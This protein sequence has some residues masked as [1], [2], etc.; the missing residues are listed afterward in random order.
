MSLGLH[1]RRA[2]RRRKFWWGVFKW[3]LAFAVIGALGVKAYYTG[4]D[5]AQRDLVAE[6]EKTSKLTGELAALNEK[7]A[8]M[9]AQ[10]DSANL[11]ASDWQKKYEVDVPTGALKELLD[12]ASGKLEGGVGMERLNFLI[13]SAQNERS[14]D[15][16]PSTKRFF[17]GTELYSGAND[18]VSFANSSITITAKGV[19]AKDSAGNVEA[20]YDSAQPIDVNFTII[21]GKTFEQSGKLPLHHSVVVKDSEYRFSLTEG[22]R[23][24]VIISGDRCDYP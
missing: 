19:S 22:P 14:C 15:N 7:V 17:V 18:S 5:I 21:G 16:A 4:S 9:K 20:W 13:R 11:S 24:F 3:L 2:K 8:D 10:L 1:E 6:Q 12:L 23:G